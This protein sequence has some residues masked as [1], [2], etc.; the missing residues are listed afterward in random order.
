MD[1]DKIVKIA[2]LDKFGSYDY[3]VPFDWLIKD[4]ENRRPHFWF[5]PVTKKRGQLFGRPLKWLA[6]ARLALRVIRRQGIPDLDEYLRLWAFTHPGKPLD[7]TGIDALNRYIKTASIVE[8]FNLEW[9]LKYYEIPLPDPGVIQ[10][11]RQVA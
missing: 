8:Q 3:A 9:V 1:L 6:V 10:D 4:P 5:Y 11:F 7:S 2:A